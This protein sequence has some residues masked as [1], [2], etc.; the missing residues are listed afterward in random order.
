MKKETKYNY[1]RFSVA[2]N[3]IFLNTTPNFNLK[4]KRILLV[5]QFSELGFQTEKIVRLNST[6]KIVKDYSS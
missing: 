2:Q 1:L 4:L 5:I 3:I 6:T